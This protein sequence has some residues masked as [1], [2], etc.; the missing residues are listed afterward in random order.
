MISDVTS[1]ETAISDHFI[2]EVSTYFKSHFVRSQKKK[3]IFY[4][5]FESLNLFDENVNWDNIKDDL[6]QINWEHEYNLITTR[7]H[8]IDKFT[9]ICEDIAV[10]HAPERTSKRFPGK[11]K[12]P[13]DRRVLMRRR[14]KVL[15]H[16]NKKQPPAQR[17]KLANELIEIEIKIQDSLSSSTEYREQRAIQAIKRNPKY[18]FSYVKKL[19]KCR[20]EV[21]PLVDK[22]KQFVTDCKGMANILSEQYSSVFSTPAASQPD[23]EELFAS[24]DPEHLVDFEFSPDDLIQ[25]IDDISE[26]A[27]AGP[28]GFAAIFLKRCKNE[29]ALPLYNIWRECLD[30]GI[31]PKSAKCSNI[32]PIHKGDSTALP[33]N[34]RPV[35]LTSH[36]VKIFEKVVCSHVVNYLEQNNLLN[37][38]QHG[39]RAGRSCLSHS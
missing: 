26:N 39:F 34:Y 29:L 27:A 13:R 12:I 9:K 20:P 37:S 6:N 21:G 1:H 19:S 24:A 36:L 30:L 28:D 33:S 5:R 31:T 10:K 18:F 17:K 14:T 16:L 3:R 25:S 35:A 22:N 38:S 7:A 32:V 2:V 4:N 23:P 11:S 15:K 8:K